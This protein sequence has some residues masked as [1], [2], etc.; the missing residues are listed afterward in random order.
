[1]NEINPLDISDLPEEAGETQ[2]NAGDKPDGSPYKPIPIPTRDIMYQHVRNFSVSQ[3]IVFD[4][5]ITYCKSIIT[6][7]RNGDA[8]S[9]VD[10]PLLIVHG[11]GGVGKS[12]LIHGIAQW[13]EKI[14]REG[15]G[16]NNQDMPMVLLLAYT[17]VAA[18]NIGGITFHSGLGF[19]F[20]SHMLDLAPQKLDMAQKYLE[21]VEVI[22]VYE[23]SLVSSDNL[24][25]LN[26]RLQEI[27]ASEDIFGG[28]CV[29]LIGDILQLPPIRAPAIFLPPRNFDSLVLFESPELNLWENCQSVLLT[30][31]FRQGQ[32]PWLK[33]LNRFRI[34]E[35]TEED[36]KVLQSRQSSLLS[37]AEYNDAS[38][39]CYTNRET[40]NHNNNMLN[41]A[42]QDEILEQ[43]GAN[44]KTPKS[45][46]PKINE[47]GLIDNSQFAMNLRLKRGAR[48]MIISNIDIKDS[49]VNGSLGMVLEIVKEE[50]QVISVIIRFDDD[51][52]GLDQ[53]E[54]HRGKYWQHIKDKGVPIFRSIQKYQIP[55]KKNF[56]THGAMC[57][58]KQFPLKLAWAL[59]GHKVQGI[60]IKRPTKV[61]VHGHPRIPPSMY[62]LMFS[63]AQD[64]EQV[65][66][67]NFTNVIKANEK[68]LIENDNLIQRSIVPS[69]Q[70]KYFNIF[71]VNIQSLENKIIDLSKDI[72]AQRLTTFVLW[73]LG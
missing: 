60:T 18:N 9:I 44:L 7:E 59:T 63:R 10:P 32:G 1:M 39:L 16:R 25:N 28:K 64:L 4:M 68:S 36:I 71:M 47:F 21:I 43:I 23:M 46:N 20:G 48:V 45:Y 55:H 72:Y 12:Y 65:Y 11:G 66:V 40:N 22:I 73:R 57:E 31:N 58:I 41:K 8:S 15:N 5:V 62:Y 54:R 67:E 37:E 30:E 26:K 35:A 50:D 69:F 19:K 42:L 29:L 17:G 53:M 13:A 33:M 27:F 2:N 51:K 38:H 24:Y 49:L 52:A 3:R 70:D 6:A 14:L 56:K 34:G 61:V